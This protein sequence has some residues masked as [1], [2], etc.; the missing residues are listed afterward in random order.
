[1]LQA[2]IRTQESNK[3]DKRRGDVI[4]IKLKEYAD[5]GSMEIRIHKVVNWEDDELEESMRGQFDNTGIPPVFTTPYKETEYTELTENGQVISEEIITKTRSRRYFDL[6]SNEQKIKSDER[7]HTEFELNKARAKIEILKSKP[8]PVNKTFANTEE[9]LL[10]S[11][12]RNLN[13]Q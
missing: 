13:G 10:D 4:C 5:W 1:M 3:S 7:V 12:R 2:L 11:Y 9:D 6:E 8:S